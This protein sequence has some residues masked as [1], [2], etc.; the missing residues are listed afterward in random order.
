MRNLKYLHI[1]KRNLSLSI[2][3]TVVVLL[4][5]GLIGSFI[6]TNTDEYKAKAL[7]NEL[8]NDYTIGQCDSIL[9]TFPNTECVELVKEKKRSLLRQKGMWH[10]ISKRPTIEALMQLKN[11]PNLLKRYAILADEKL[12]SL[13][14][15]EAQK[16]KTQKHYEEYFAL[17]KMTRYH[18]ETFRVLQAM[19]NLP[20]PEAVQEQI[21]VSV[22]D[23]YNN[24][25]NTQTSKVVEACADTVKLFLHRGN[26]DK[27]QLTDYLN[28]TYYKKVKKRNFT[29]TSDIAIHK[30]RL[31][32]DS[33]GYA[34]VCTMDEEIPGKRVRKSKSLILFNTDR[35]IV[36]VKI[37]RVFNGR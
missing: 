3:A 12:D 18:N 11:T 23:F 28:K 2:I 4:F 13:V 14:W 37:N 9:K 8:G 35:K 26:I 34:A 27:I 29:I 16:G 20:N 10:A 6:Y 31:A 32:D 25:G 21:Q 1:M 24:L 5:V 30:A 15:V 7:Y 33:Y 17:G 36:Y 22:K 19:Q